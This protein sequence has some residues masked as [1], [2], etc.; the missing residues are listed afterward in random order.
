MPLKLPSSRGSFRLRLLPFDVFWAAAAPLL[1]LYLR[2]AYILSAQDVRNGCALLQPLVSLRSNWFFGIPRQRRHTAPFIPPRRFQHLE[3]DRS[4]PR[5]QP[6]S[7]SSPSRASKV[8]HARFPSFRLCSL[9]LGCSQR[10][11]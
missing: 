2:D 9:L 4:S 1:A 6:P 8:F 11:S 3:G 5:W 7:S 10:A